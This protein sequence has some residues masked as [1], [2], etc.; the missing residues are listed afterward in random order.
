MFF[1]EKKTKWAIPIFFVMILVLVWASPG[2]KI[3]SPDVIRGVDQF[4]SARFDEAIRTLDSAISSGSL[5]KD[6]LFAAHLYMAFS[7]LRQNAEPSVVDL[8][9]VEAIRSNPN[10]AVDSTRIPPDLYER[11]MQT[12]K[13]I[14]GNL[15]VVTVPGAASAIL[16]GQQGE[17]VMNQYTPALFSN[18]LAGEYE[19]LIA[20]EG[21]KPRTASPVVRAGVTDTLMITLVEKKKSFLKSYWPWGGSLLIATSIAISRLTGKEAKKEDSTLPAPPGRPEKP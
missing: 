6:D 16:F 20:K 18:L 2:Q 3:S 13:R 4:Y 11:Y 15:L 5:P 10:L 9:F 19:L 14:L 17:K 7:Y 12:R 1:R 8:H 21:Y